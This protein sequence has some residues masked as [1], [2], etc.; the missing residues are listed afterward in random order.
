MS[1]QLEKR[2]M[3]IVA[4]PDDAE[5]G[6]A[7]TVAALVRDG[8]EMFYVICSDGSGGG[9]DDAREVGPEARRHISEIRKREQRSACRI[10]GVKEVHFLDY[11]DGSIEP[12]MDLRRDLVRLMRRYRPTRVFIQSPERTWT[13]VLAIPRHHPD[14]LAAGEAAMRAIYPACQNPWDFPE[15]LLHE[16]LEPHRIREVYIMGAPTSNY[17]IDITGTLEMKLE[18]LQAHE[19]QLPDFSKVAERVRSWGTSIGEKY[20]V[21]YAEEFHRTEN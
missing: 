3:V 9:S 16:G 2:G 6:C 7:G 10:L 11:P 20:G 14:H 5:F 19:S 18:A 8:W 4:H 17:H 21:K 1:E 13:P 15:L 12:T